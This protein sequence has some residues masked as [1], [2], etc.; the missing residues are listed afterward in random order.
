[1]TVCTLLFVFL[2]LWAFVLA[3]ESSTMSTSLGVVGV[4]GALLMPIYGVCFYRKAAR[5]HI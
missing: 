4:A 5:I 3:P 2:A 1:M